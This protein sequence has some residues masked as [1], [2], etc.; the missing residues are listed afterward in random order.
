MI[1][2]SMARKQPS[3]GQLIAYMNKDSD[4]TGGTLFSRNLYANPM[5]TK[6]VEGEFL[7][8]FKLLAKR[9]NGNAMY[10]ELIVLEQ[11]SKMSR[12]NANGVLKD[13]AEE[14]LAARAPN[15]IVFG[16]IHHDRAHSHIHL[17]ISSNAV[18]SEKR[19]RVDRARFSQ[20]QVN[21][22][23]YKIQKYPELD[24]RHTYK[25]QSTSETPKLSNREAEQV[26]RTGKLS[27]KQKLAQTIRPLISRSGG[28]KELSA[29]LKTIGYRLYQRG[30]HIGLE[31]LGEG[32]RIRLKT[33]GLE[34]AMVQ[35]LEQSKTQEQLPQ[36]NRA[37]ALLRRRSHLDREA[38]NHLQEFE[39]ER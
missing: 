8:N 2:K 7:K 16:R 11:N 28:L 23:S 22:E 29:K 14:Y 21:I 10:H 9:S 27:A 39:G 24:Q 6:Q 31:P 36:D 3:F 38:E 30:K 15:N 17:L 5:H 18:R 35:L 20:I 26:H 34:N 32:R 4:K 19:T 12:K 1:I 33:L 25:S 37:K 13:L